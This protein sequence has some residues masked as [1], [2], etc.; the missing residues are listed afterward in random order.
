MHIYIHALGRKRNVRK[1]LAS[2]IAGGGT[3]LGRCL[4]LVLGIHGVFGYAYN[5][6]LFTMAGNKS[7]R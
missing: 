5:G 4:G 3:R 7:D 6:L 1:R 2:L